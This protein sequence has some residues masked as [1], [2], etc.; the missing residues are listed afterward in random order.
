[1]LKELIMMEQLNFIFNFFIRPG[2]TCDIMTTER[3]GEHDL[4]IIWN[5]KFDFR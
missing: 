5:A 4:F 3:A 1:M 2:G